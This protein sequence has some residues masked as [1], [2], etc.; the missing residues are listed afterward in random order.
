MA[1]RHA[2]DPARLGRRLA[3][4]VGRKG[5]DP[6]EECAAQRRRG[7]K[8]TKDTPN[9]NGP[10]P[11]NPRSSPKIVSSALLT[12]ADGMASSLSSLP[13]SLPA[14]RT[15]AMGGGKRVVKWA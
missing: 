9:G 15:A 3:A 12:G 6:A 10:R 1:D 11:T 13:V 2:P 4:G 14:R 5:V 7:K 8:A